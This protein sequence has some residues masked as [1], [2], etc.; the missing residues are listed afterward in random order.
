MNEFDLGYPFPLADFHTEFRVVPEATRGI[1]GEPT[2]LECEAPRGHPEPQIRWRKNGHPL[3][4]QAQSGRS[5]GP[6]S[7]LSIPRSN[8]PQSKVNPG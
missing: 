5:V 1:L 3:E 8:P 7:R 4:V 6:I 2:T